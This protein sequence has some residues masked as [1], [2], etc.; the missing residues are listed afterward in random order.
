LCRRYSTAYPLTPE[1]LGWHEAGHVVVAHRLGYAVWGVYHRAPDHWET[2]F[3][4]PE[5]GSTDWGL[6]AVAGYLSEGRAIGHEDPAEAGEI[7]MR[8]PW[9]DDDSPHERLARVRQVERDALAILEEHWDT[10]GRVAELIRSKPFITG[11]E[12]AGALEGV[13][14]ADAG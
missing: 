6:I 14:R 4:T 9:H 8:G 13:R 1:R 10:V 12:L 5:R 2:T 3:V 7:S 11:D